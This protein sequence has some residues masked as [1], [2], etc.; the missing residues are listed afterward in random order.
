M[1]KL[2]IVITLEVTKDTFSTPVKTVMKLVL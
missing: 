2:N 1:G